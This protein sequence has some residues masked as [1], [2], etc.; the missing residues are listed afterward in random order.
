MSVVVVTGAGGFIGSHVTD[1]LLQRGDDVLALDLGRK[2][3]PNLAQAAERPGFTYL[4]CDVTRPASAH[5]AFASRPSSVV[6]AAAG[7]G[8]ESYMREPMNTIESSV[9]GT[10]NM[11]RE[12]MKTNSRFLYLSSSELFGR[13]PVLPWTETSDRVLGDPSLSRWTYSTSKGLCEHLVNAA[14]AQS[15]LPTSIVRPFNIYGPRQRPAFVIPITIH[16]VLNGRPPVIYGDGTQTRCFTYIDDLVV[17]ILKCLDLEAATGEAFNM[18]YP[19]EWQIRDAIRI[20][21]E[22]CRSDLQPVHEDPRNTFG[23]GFDEIG[24]RLIDISKA[25]RLLGWTPGTGLAGGVGATV[26]WARSHPEWLRAG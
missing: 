18:G 7:V 26:A 12:S 6:H 23:T 10:R 14:R 24:R 9:I 25:T 16:R 13:N 4:S 11:L 21:S 22:T 5:R 1:A 3:S 17:G 15:G 8:V 20:V 2:P 19:E